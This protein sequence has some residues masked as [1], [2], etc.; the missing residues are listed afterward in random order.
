VRFLIAAIMGVLLVILAAVTADAQTG[1]TAKCDGLTCGCGTGTVSCGGTRD[2]VYRVTGP[3][4]TGWPDTVVWIWTDDGNPAHYTNICMPSGWTFSITSEPKDHFDGCWPRGSAAPGHGPIC[5]YVIEFMG[6]GSNPLSAVPTDFGFDYTPEH[7]CHTVEWRVQHITT[8]VSVNWADPVGLGTGPVH[9]PHTCGDLREV[10]STGWDE[11]LL[12]QIPVGSPDD[13]WR[14]IEIPNGYGQ[15]KQ[16]DVPATVTS[17]ALPPGMVNASWIGGPPL[18]AR[19]GYYWFEYQF[20]LGE[21]FWDPESFLLDIGGG[22]MGNDSL[23]F[24][25]NGQLV[26]GPFAGGALWSLG[27]PYDWV[28]GKN[29]IQV[30][31]GTDATGSNA[32]FILSGQVIADNGECC[33][34]GACCLC[35]DATHICLDTDEK[36]CVLERGRFHPKVEC[37]QINCETDICY[38]TGDINDDH[39][40]L[41]VADLAALI[42]YVNRTNPNMLPPK[43]LWQCDLNA[44]GKI[45][46]GDIDIL[47][48]YFIVGLSA[49]PVYPV[50]V[51]CCP[52]TIRAACCEAKGCYVRHKDNCNSPGATFLPSVSMCVPDP[53]PKCLGIMRGNANYDLNDKVNVADVTYLLSWLFGIPSGPAPACIFEAN[54]NGDAGEKVNVTDV[55]YLLTYLFG[56]PAGP[57]PPACP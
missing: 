42:S 47:K 53:C 7:D 35:E 13:D 18:V 22:C 16:V 15:Q 26:A 34:S 41:G 49:F 30:K 46:Q 10:I 6:S 23:W 9:S 19:P 20:C 48:L 31:L 28:Y 24:Y 29:T 1:V 12:A 44:D 17:N 14:V 43:D 52:D 3:G 51:D 27:I 11:N 4:I 21:D 50:P 5:R 57:P 25:F 54:A 38:A 56:I 45:D 8:T 33:D 55:T 2:Y 39:I 40:N 32:A 36:T 37:S